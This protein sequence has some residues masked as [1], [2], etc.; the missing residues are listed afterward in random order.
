MKMKRKNWK[1][2]KVWASS[3]LLGY[4][5]KYAFCPLYLHKNHIPQSPRLLWVFLMLFFLMS[6]PC[7]TCLRVRSASALSILHSY[8]LISEAFT[9]IG[10]MHDILQRNIARDERKRLHKFLLRKENCNNFFYPNDNCSWY[11]N[12]IDNIV[13]IKKIL[14]RDLLKWKYICGL[15]P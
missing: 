7:C 4:S 11:M 2:R 8:Y 1:R 3:V 9:Y 10:H 13:T 12:I 14:I 15:L 5:V 6:L